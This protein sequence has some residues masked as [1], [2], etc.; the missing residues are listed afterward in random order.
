MD[1]WH[2]TRV[3]LSAT[4][5]GWGS[6]MSG[7]EGR[8]KRGDMNDQRFDDLARRLAASS[9]RR[10]VIKVL[11]AGI[12]GVLLSAVGRNPAS[13]ANDDCAHFCNDH[14]SGED[15]GD[16]KSAGAH[17]QGLCYSACGPNGPSGQTGTLCGG[18][19]LSTTTCC[20]SGQTTCINGACCPNANA[21]GS[22][23]LGAPCN[24]AQCL[25]C[26]ASTGTC[27]STCSTANC[28]TCNGSGTCVS[29][30]NAAQCQTC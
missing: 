12:A 29:T 7:S 6:P 30:C 21:C 16:C 8:G 20:V 9:S 19:S 3:P 18:P 13:A 17:H 27:V 24:T 5:A 23:C 25:T 28:Q 11:G 14:F 4:G 22:T 15:R 10:S 2:G 1:P 26:Q